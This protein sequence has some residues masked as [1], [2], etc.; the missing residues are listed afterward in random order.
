MVKVWERA[1]ES[2]GRGG[3]GEKEE[4]K[5]REVESRKVSES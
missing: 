4:L 5:S 2:R 3:K 1:I